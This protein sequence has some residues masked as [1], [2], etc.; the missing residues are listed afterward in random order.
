MNQVAKLIFTALF[1]SLSFV[2]NAQWYK[3]SFEVMG[4]LSHVEFWLDEQT[5]SLN[6]SS[7][8]TNRHDKAQVLI[9]QVE[10][11]MFRI[12][13]Q[14]SPYKEQSELSFVNREAANRA[15]SISAELF[16]L[17]SVAQDLSKISDG[18]FDITYAS[19]G[20][21]YNYRDKKRPSQTVISKALPAINY[22]AVTLRKENSTIFFDHQGMK[23]DLG[24]IVQL[25]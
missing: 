3:H 19:I 11:E 24:G 25:T 7:N 12:D 22:T 15:V 17:L 5:V 10:Q 4:T 20:Y 18:A 1:L 2:A 16:S 14:M 9:A 6:G 13:Q 21:Q 23:I 8:E